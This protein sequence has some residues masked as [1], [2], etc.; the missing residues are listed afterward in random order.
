[1]SNLVKNAMWAGIILA[2]SAQPANACW[3]D[4]ATDA[5][6]IKHLNTMLMATA[7]RCRNTPDDF[8]PDYN[9]FV[10]KHNDMLGAQ[11]AIVRLEL[12]KTLGKGGAVAR[13]D[14]L[15]VGYANAYGAGHPSM[16]CR[17]LK[18][19][20]IEITDRASDAG[21]FSILAD[22]VLNPTD[23]PGVICKVEPSR[24]ASK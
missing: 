5:L 18:S 17:Q 2:I 24:I 16:N 12:A 3:N 23:I 14:N 11:N 1:V 6:K 13:S 9:A 15:S 19:F 8:L 20:A 4:K 7:L 22:R 21:N 10:K